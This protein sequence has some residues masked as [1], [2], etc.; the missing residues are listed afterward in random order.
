VDYYWEKLSAPKAQQCGW[1]KDKYG[2]SWQVVPSVLASLI[3]DPNSEKSQRATAAMLTM[4]KF[5]IAALKR[6]YAG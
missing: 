5:D 3:K 1:L 6:A 4:K 2:V